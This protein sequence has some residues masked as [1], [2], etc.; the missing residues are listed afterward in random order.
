MIERILAVAAIACS[1]T[2]VAA[3]AD[4]RQPTGK[5]VV[6]F[7]DNECL[8]SRAY[9]TDAEPLHLGF[10]QV[11]MSAGIQL[12]VL[13]HSTDATLDGGE[14]RVSFGGRAPIEAGYGAFRIGKS[15][16][17]LAINVDNDSYKAAASG[18]EVLSVEARGE[19]SESFAVPGFG[20]ALNVLRQ[21]VLDLGVQWGIP[22]EQ[23]Q[24]LAVAA[25]PLKKDIRRYFDAAD[26]PADALR[27]GAS[28]RSFVRLSV[29][30]SGRPTDCTVVVSSG[31]RAL[32]SA[33]CRVL[34]NRARFEPALDRAGQ[35]MSTV[36]AA[37]VYWITR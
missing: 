20:E 7:A 22:L 14:A 5:W 26:Y 10:I 15:L 33:T 36:A 17:R 34:L 30:V 28:G 27:T 9:G 19:I 35:A 25:K 2:G 11:P 37:N 24:R 18:P 32:D 1:G 6:E 31:H 23:Q 8:L 21:C 12:L 29:D 16:R 3:A 13:K 4:A